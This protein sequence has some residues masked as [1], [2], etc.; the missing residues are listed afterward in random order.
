MI[1]I[2]FLIISGMIAPRFFKQIQKPPRDP[3]YS[4]MKVIK[5]AI[6][7]YKFNI[8]TIPQ[9]LEDL[10]VCP[11]GIENVWARPYLKERMLYD[12]W[13]RPFVY[14]PNTTSANGYDLISY[15]RD[16]LPGGEDYNA[17]IHND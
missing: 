5:Y 17:D 2:I 13:N 11:Q 8:G 4:Q 1:L 15:G 9:T 6:N 10:L 14:E 16:G 3:V 7:T 12:S